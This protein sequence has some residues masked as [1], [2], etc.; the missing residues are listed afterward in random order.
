MLAIVVGAAIG[1]ALGHYWGDYDWQTKQTGYCALV[2]AF[3]A[4]ITAR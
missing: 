1:A 3:I 2:G 4:A